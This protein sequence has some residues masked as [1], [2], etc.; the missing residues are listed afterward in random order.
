MCEFAFSRMLQEID[1]NENGC[2]VAACKTQALKI[3]VIEQRLLTFTYTGQTMSALKAVS[4]HMD[5]AEA[6]TEAKLQQVISVAALQNYPL[7]RDLH[8]NV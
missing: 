1:L 6:E 8:N 3:Q 7:F 5:A 2:L 4:Q